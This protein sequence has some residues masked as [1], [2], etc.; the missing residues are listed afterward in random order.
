MNREFMADSSGLL[1]KELKAGEA[2][3]E[4]CSGRLRPS[5]IKQPQPHKKKVTQ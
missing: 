2:T 1:R 5:K 3:E 4:G